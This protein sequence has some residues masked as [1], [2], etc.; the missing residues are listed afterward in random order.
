MVSATKAAHSIAW[1]IFT[2]IGSRAL[3]VIGTL[4]LTRYLSPAD[5]GEVSGAFVIVLSVNQFLTFGVGMYL[6]A[7]PEAGRDIAFHAS[8]LH[9]G[10]G[11]VALLLAVAGQ[12]P[13]AQLFSA[14]GLA[15]YVPG[16][17]LATL[18]SRV[19]YMPERILVRQ[20][21]FR[22]LGVSRAV[23]E[24]ALPVV[25]VATAHAG[26]GGYALI[27]GNL[28]RSLTEFFMSAPAVDRRD[29]LQPTRLSWPTL[30]MLIG[31]GTWQSLSALAVVAT[32]RWDNLLISRIYGPGVM[33]AYNLAY[34]LADIP[35]IQVGEQI[36]DVL[37]SS[38][39][40]IEHER[41][42]WALLRATGLLALIMFPLAIGLGA[43]APTL[44]AIFLD[45]R[46]VEVG[47]YLA[48]LSAM[49]I[50]RPLTGA[51]L[52]YLQVRLRVRTVAIIEWTTVALIVVLL[53]T[54]GRINPLWGC[55]G[56][57]LAFAA[58][59]GLC[60]ELLRRFE[61]VSALQILARQWRPLLAT[62][63]MVA[64]VWAVRHLFGA[65]PHGIGSLPLLLC[66]VSAGGVAYVA[67]ALTVAREPA[68]DFI[69]LARRLLRRGGE[70]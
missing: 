56:V 21:N 14:P 12:A 36:T 7:K 41:R 31:Y 51:L 65:Q 11:V 2:G 32:R 17:A 18:I 26:W 10:M 61:Q 59:L 34:N 16:L 70:S 4:V 53:F 20:M 47:P 62:V 49:A 69:D 38:L 24:I 48:A 23:A 15:K 46:W 66:E 13:L 3:G 19:A 52:S 45:P 25:A 30:K 8:V 58:R 40:N 55:I 5:M 64:A 1:T 67:A 50:S 9:I 68:H 28:A 57:G 42:D 44:V 39:A 43:V 37:L 27:W 6:V 54:V 60:L 63:P 29:W 33:G 22:R 35:S